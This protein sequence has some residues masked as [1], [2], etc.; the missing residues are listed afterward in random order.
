M[1]SFKQYIVEKPVKLHATLP[2]RNAEDK[3]IRG[4]IN[5]SESELTAYTERTPNKEVRILV[6][7]TG[8]LWVF[9]ASAAIHQEI[10]TGEGLYKE[11]LMLGVLGQDEDGWIIQF[12]KWE[13]RDK[14]AKKNK[15][16][17]KLMK[18]KDN[19]VTTY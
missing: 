6:N 2:Y 14:Y 4:L 11:D 19:E 8:K 18:N 13:G 1:I 5:P 15:T 10:I 7:K 17:A 9:N 12:S 3:D 16:L